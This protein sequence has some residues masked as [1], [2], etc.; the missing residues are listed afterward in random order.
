[1]ESWECVIVDDASPDRCGEIADE[2]A[3]RDKRFRVIHNQ[4]NQY[5]AGALNTGITAA[6]GQYVVPL[7]ADNMLAPNTLRLLADALDADRSTH[8]AYGNVLF[9]TP[10]GKPDEHW[11]GGHSGWPPPFRGDWQLYR[12]RDDG[13]PSNLI[14]STAMY[15]RQVWE[16]TGGYRGRYRT[17][18]DADFWTR[19]T[20]FG[21]R[22]AMVTKADTLIYR[23]REDSMSRV[24]EQRDWTAWLPWSST[25]GGY[26]TPAGAITDKQQPVQSYAPP[27]VA[28]VIPVG[29]KHERLLVDALDSVMAQTFDQWECVVV[30]DTGKPLPWVPSWATVIDTGGGAGVAKARNM[31]IA[32]SQSPLFVP[33][34]ADDTLE[35]SMIELTLPVYERFRGYVYCD[36]YDLKAATADQPGN[37][38]A[39][40]TPEYNAWLLADGAMHAV[41]GLFPKA[42]WTEVGGYDEGIPA[43]EDWDFQ[44]KLA[45]IGCCGTRYPAPLF[46]YRS[47]LGMRR[48]DNYANFD[49]SKAGIS[50]KWET[51]FNGKD[52][53]MGCKSCGGGGGQ[54]GAQQVRAPEVKIDLPEDVSGYVM[55]EYIGGQ[56][57]DSIF[58]GQVSGQSYRFGNNETSRLRYVLAA[59][60][61][62]FTKRIDFRVVL[63]NKVPADV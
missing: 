34:D 54:V 21:F 39:W 58:K 41:T 16:L 42:A 62:P 5:L 63:P 23:N 44:L 53:L 22:A 55:V 30:N 3:A 7:D 24:T 35:P 51:Y 15:R 40:E 36:W 32:S 12:R 37:L 19:A 11:P 26:P 14:P 46:T 1:V 49:V 28:V 8:I 38:P 59:D 50:A 4:D 48:N 6:R 29:P 57:A 56:E 13:G 45:A 20:S 60:A 25:Q 52:T 31:G 10:E 2:Y 47:D 43:W 17:A 18:E 33:L 27:L 9:V 61:D